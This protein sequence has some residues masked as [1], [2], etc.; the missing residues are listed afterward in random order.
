MVVVGTEYGNLE[1]M[2]RLQRQAHAAD[3]T[4][5]AQQFPH[6][7]T[8]SA[9]TFI[10]IAKTLTGGNV[11][12]NAGCNTPVTALLHAMLHLQ[13]H[14]H[15]RSHVFVGD[16]YCEES[17][18]DVCKRTHSTCR[19]TPGVCYASLASGTVFQAELAFGDRAFDICIGGASH[20]WGVQQTEE[21]NGA[22]ALNW[23]LSM[24]RDLS[25][26]ETVSLGT[27]AAGR[28]AAVRITRQQSA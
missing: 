4:I 28:R 25:I 24:A 14:A 7:T 16:A 26:G 23:L 5:S 12:L 2:L 15:G 10:N 20:L 21:H 27:Q 3:K 8:S 1:A 6:A 19:I 11:T 17:V 22:F 18:S 13:A 9:S